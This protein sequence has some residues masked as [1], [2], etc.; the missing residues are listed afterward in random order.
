MPLIVERSYLL[1][2]RT[3]AAKRVVSI[4]AD[5]ASEIARRVAAY[6]LSEGRRR[7]VGMVAQMG[8]ELAHGANTLYESEQ[9]YAG[10]ALVRQLIEVEYVLWLFGHDP[11]EVDRWCSAR[12]DDLR[13][14]F[15]PAEM[16]KRSNGYFD[17]DEYSNHCTLGGHPRK[18]GVALL[19]D[20]MTVVDGKA[21]EALV[22]TELWVDLAQH[23]VRVWK[24][25]S[26]AV[27]LHSPTNIYP[28]KTPA[29]IRTRSLVIGVGCARRTQTRHRQRTAKHFGA[30]CASYSFVALPRGF[31]HFPIG[32][33][34]SKNR[35]DSA[36]QRNAS[37]NQ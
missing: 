37:R 28:E 14:D 2:D 13:Q 1:D 11:A 7:A 3:I 33:A 25:L 10:A 8:A 5:E 32:D 16:R 29:S 20:W 27:E 26:R 34:C 35:M 30:R 36:S 6:G 12:P 18:A 31:S 24:C 21:N 22:P 23:V 19:H 17:A 4:I 15:S 9:W